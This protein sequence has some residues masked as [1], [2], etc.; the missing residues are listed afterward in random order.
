VLLNLKGIQNNIIP[1]AHVLL[2]KTKTLYYSKFLS[3]LRTAEVFPETF[4]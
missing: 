3:G 1:G 4:C 2:K